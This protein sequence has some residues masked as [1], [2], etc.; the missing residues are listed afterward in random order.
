MQSCL[1]LEELTHMHP[2]PHSVR[3]K[4]QRLPA[5]GCEP[6]ESLSNPDEP[7]ASSLDHA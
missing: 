2:I 1:S 4:G 3:S 6:A 5:T 7:T